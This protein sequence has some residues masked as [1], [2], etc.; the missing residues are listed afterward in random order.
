MLTSALGVGIRR[1]V[2]GPRHPRWGAK[3]EITVQA[4]RRAI[5]DDP[6]R[7]VERLRALPT[8]PLSRSL[9]ARVTVEDTTLGDVQAKVVT[10]EG[11][12]SGEPTCLYA[13][14]GGYVSGSAAQ[15]LDLTARLALGAGHRVVSLDYRLAPEHPFPAALDDATSAWT[16]LR[17]G[18]SNADWVAGDSAGG[19]LALAL[20]VRLRNDD[21]HVPSC[22]VGFSPFLDVSREATE[23]IEAPLDFLTPTLLRAFAELYAG[24]ER[25]DHP[26]VSPVFA[27]LAGLPPLFVSTGGAELLGPEQERLVERA[28][29]ADVEVEHLV[30]EGMPHNYAGLASVCPTGVAAIE[31]AGAFAVRHAGSGR[32]A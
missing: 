8:M 27:D 20:C 6:A 3:L 23:G 25:A 14:G 28:R 31:A 12:R 29:A 26:L 7:F 22:W 30:D 32:N 11:W 4:A 19:G 9:A 1:L 2:R 13:H 17:D 15:V 24:D 5:G 16:A 10:P 18:G 21:R